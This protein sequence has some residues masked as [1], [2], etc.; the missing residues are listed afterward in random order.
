MGKKLYLK[1][2]IEKGVL[3]RKRERNNIKYNLI[4]VGIGKDCVHERMY[5]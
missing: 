4:E 3:E 1:S 5:L 2:G